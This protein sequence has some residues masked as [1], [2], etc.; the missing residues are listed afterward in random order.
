MSRDDRPNPP[1][2]SDKEDAMANQHNNQNSRT[3]EAQHNLRAYPS[4]LHEILSITPQEVE[5][6]L[7]AQG[8]TPAQAL[9][10]FD[11]LITALRSQRL[12]APADH[13]EIQ[14]FEDSLESLRFYEES[15]AAGIPMD[16]GGEV[17]YRKAR[18]SD[19]FG[20]Q[21][22]TSMFV[23]KVSGWSMCE[24]HITDGDVVL[25]DSK[26][27][28]K[29]G[30]IVLAYIVGEGQVVKRLRIIDRDQLVLES[31]N[32]DFKSIVIDDPSRVTI[33]GVVKGRAGKI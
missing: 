32:P 17:P 10:E 29:D 6:E 1:P 33:R 23:A 11:D 16:E 12:S 8:K 21:D 3:I 13:D 7:H 5:A 19:F 27:R 24:D 25:V 18:G 26:A 30:D 15:V 9:A 31:A 20:H 28:P 4:R 2:H 14:L 22:W